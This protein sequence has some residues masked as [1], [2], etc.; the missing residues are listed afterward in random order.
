MASIGRLDRSLTIVIIAHR[1][2]TLEGCDT[3]VRLEKGMIVRP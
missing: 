3:V 2:S 1:L